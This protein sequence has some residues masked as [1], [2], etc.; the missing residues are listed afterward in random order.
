MRKKFELLSL[1]LF[2]IIE[3]NSSFVPSPYRCSERLQNKFRAKTA[4]EDDQKL[5]WLEE[6]KAPTGEIVDPYKV[7]KI[8]RD[9]NVTEIKQA[10]RKLSRKYHPDTLRFRDVLPGS[11]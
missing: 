2:I 6:F 10:Y 7:L 4:T 3:S 1:L 9:A 5:Y 8:R 11:W